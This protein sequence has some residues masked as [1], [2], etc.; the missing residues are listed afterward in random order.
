MCIC[1]WNN[2]S[3]RIAAVLNVWWLQTSPSEGLPRV[4]ASL[5]KSCWQQA[6]KLSLHLHFKLL[7]KITV[8]ST[9]G[10]WGRKSAHETVARA[11]LR[12]RKLKNWQTQTSKRFQV[13]NDVNS[14]VRSCSVGFQLIVMKRI[15]TAAPRKQ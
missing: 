8:K 1:V 15:G 6:N 3:A 7:T 11:G 4:R 12:E 14:M 2:G 13:R 10:K 9:S 5:C